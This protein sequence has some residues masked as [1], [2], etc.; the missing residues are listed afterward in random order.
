MHAFIDY[1]RHH[2]LRVLAAL[3]AITVAAGWAASKL[4]LDANLTRL[5]PQ[6]AP[7]VRGL[8]ALETAYGG[9]IGRLSIVLEGTDRATLEDLA[10]QLDDDLTELAGVRRVESKK[11][12]R[13]FRR[14]RLLYADY[15]DLREVEQRLDTRIRWEKERANPLFVPLGDDEP[16]ALDFT[17]LRGK[18]GNLDQSGYYVGDEG[19]TLAIFVYPSFPS[20]DLDQSRALSDRVRALLD[21]ELADHPRVDYGL[22]GRYRKRVDLQD[23]LESDLG[24]ATTVAIAMLALLLLGFLRSPSALLVVGLP[25]LTGTIWAMAWAQIA[26]GS[27]NILTGFLAAVLL[28]IGVDYGIHLYIRYQQMRETRPAGEA[29]AETFATSGRANL[30]GGI[31]TAVALSSLIVAEFRAFYEF[32]VISLGGIALI[33]LAFALMTP[34]LVFFFERKEHRFRAPISLLLTR[35]LDSWLRTDA[36]ALLPRARRLGALSLGVLLIV[37]ALGLPR[38]DFERS[39]APL[40]N[41]N[42]SSWKLD[43][44]INALL[45]QSQTPTVV[46]TDSPEHSQRIIEE[47]RR[48]RD[49]QPGGDTIDKV[50]S[51]RTVLPRRQ[52]E[53]IELLETMLDDLQ[54]V[55]PES[56]SDKLTSYSDEVA[57]VLDAGPLGPE[58]LPVAV[59]EPFRTRGGQGGIVLVFPAIDLAEIDQVS[60]FVGVL[61]D[62]P[63]VEAPGRYDAISEAL[64]LYDIVRLVERDAAW[65]LG[66]TLAGLLF[67]SVAA[68]GRRRP[69]LLQLGIQLAGF[70]SALGLAA[71][72]GIELNFLNVII[73]PIWLGLGVDA[74]F[75]I[76]MH[77]H[78]HPGDL[79]A[80][81][82]TATA[83]AGAF[84]TSMVGFGAMLLA[85]HQGLFSLGAIAVIG[86][87]AILA[88][89]L[90]AHL[91]LVGG[92]TR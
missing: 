29:L 17:D 68:F 49:H 81:L 83:I 2:F 62:L 15:D 42:S 21:E 79:S 26:F 55:P 85:D 71:W 45:G 18:Y 65:M 86:L 14:F 7:S 91:M 57:D 50:V 46:L 89:N 59:R 73:L 48:R 40:E 56:R 32:G 44:R 52:H 9:Q 5:L 31:T 34:P 92:S 76:L 77:L 8:E 20:T 28:G 60:R 64:L 61:Q 27:L 70:V 75:H 10:D 90:L 80:H 72:A 39:F 19:R 47:L 13:F 11:P 67:V 54:E 88:V 37:A 25:L 30:Y 16:P 53:K 58:E 69:V 82:A 33:L 24:L 22:T 84:T 1:C 23:T 38:L 12:V 78:Q 4:E 41:R 87:S 35:R 51:L 6:Q 63:G 43:Q 3:L 74:S 36:R 66:L